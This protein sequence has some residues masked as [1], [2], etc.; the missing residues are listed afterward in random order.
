M[1]NVP[2]SAAEKA[3]SRDIPADLHDEVFEKLSEAAWGSD[4]P[5]VRIIHSERRNV[6]NVEVVGSIDMGQG[7]EFSFHLRDGDMNG[8]E[9]IGW[10][11]AGTE[12]RIPHEDPVVT[13]L[14][15][16][17][18]RVADARGPQSAAT[19]LAQ[20]DAD[21][22][23]GTQ[24]SRLP[25][26]AA[27]DAFFAPGA[28]ASRPHHEKAEKAGYE[29]VEESV[30]FSRRKALI[31]EVLGV[32]PI[33]HAS[34]PEAAKRV[35]LGWAEASDPESDVG[36]RVAALR[37]AYLSRASRI[38]HDK[39]RLPAPDET[40][41]MADLGYS[42]CG[43]SDEARKR[44]ALLGLLVRMEPVEGFDPRHLPKSPFRVMFNALDP[45][46]APD[47]R[48]IP[49]HEAGRLC[50]SL[51]RRMAAM[52]EPSIPDEYHAAAARFGYRVLMEDIFPK[53]TEDGPDGPSG[54]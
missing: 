5:G 15:P 2:M 37:E 21:T 44:S 42:F 29:I 49:E 35:L 17:F 4:I 41:A 3:F 13:V 33:A 28:G 36:G 20:W 18:W 11:D 53:K 50:E 40:S 10:E 30:A 51:I 6:T 22:G 48:V 54:P 26:A 23:P 52:T 32:A 27:Y 45:S 24:L 9:L 12:I 38:G 31:G 39:S 25:A 14:A 34:T 16:A 7:R 8:T 46:L 47:T 19:L 43:R 1:K